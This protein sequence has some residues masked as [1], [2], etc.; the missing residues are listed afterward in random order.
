MLVVTWWTTALKFVE[1]LSVM[2]NRNIRGS[3][4]NFVVIAS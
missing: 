3:N 4:F 2:N 1:A